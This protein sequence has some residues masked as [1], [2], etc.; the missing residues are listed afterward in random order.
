MKIL[1]N[2]IQSIEKNK[3]IFLSLEAS[4]NHEAGKKQNPEIKEHEFDPNEYKAKQEKSL[5]KITQNEQ[6]S[7]N[8]GNLE[9]QLTKAFQDLE[10]N[11]TQ[12]AE[13]NPSKT[14]DFSDVSNATPAKEYLAAFQNQ[15]GPNSFQSGMDYA[16]ATE[17]QFALKKI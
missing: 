12:V 15:F 5:A 4:N 13:N 14:P 7:L 2:N 10:N 3:F 11:P 8:T 6:K 16:K 1:K 17:Q 9:D